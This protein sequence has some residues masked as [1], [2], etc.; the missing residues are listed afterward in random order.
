MNIEIFYKWNQNH[1][2]LHITHSIYESDQRSRSSV[3]FSNFDKTY[4]CMQRVPL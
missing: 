1:N 3:V 4:L 2:I